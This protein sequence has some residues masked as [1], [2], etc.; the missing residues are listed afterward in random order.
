MRQEFGAAGV[1][2]LFCLLVR[3]ATGRTRQ[4]AWL[5]SFPGSFGSAVRNG[6]ARRVR[7]RELGLC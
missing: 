7:P 5:V 1:V 3:L 2:A 6:V 4:R